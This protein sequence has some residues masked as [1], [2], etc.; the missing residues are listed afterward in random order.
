VQ[1]GVGSDFE[2]CVCIFLMVNPQSKVSSNQSSICHIKQPLFALTVL[3]TH[4]RSPK[5]LEYEKHKYNTQNNNRI[6]KFKLHCQQTSNNQNYEFLNGV[7]DS[8]N[9]DLND[10]LNNIR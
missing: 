8:A 7:A 6:D 5:I 4:F 9:P 10:W 2:L 1:A 3:F